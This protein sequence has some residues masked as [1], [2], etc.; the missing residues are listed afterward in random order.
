MATNVRTLL[1]AEEERIKRT[2]LISECCAGIAAQGNH[3]LAGQRVDLESNGLF[4]TE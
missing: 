2:Q 1:T 4:T 3:I